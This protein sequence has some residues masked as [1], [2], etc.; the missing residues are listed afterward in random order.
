MEYLFNKIEHEI[1]LIN[2]LAQSFNHSIKPVRV[3][4]LQY[5]ILERRMS[6]SL[7]RTGGNA[8]R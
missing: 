7:V 4:R 1:K 2:F 6:F 3:E 5:R 8:R